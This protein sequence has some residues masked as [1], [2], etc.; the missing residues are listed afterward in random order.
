VK[1]GVSLQ[2]KRGRDSA[3]GIATRY[4]L[5]GP[6]SSPGGGETF[7]AHPYRHWSLNSLVYNGYR[8]FPGSKAAGAWR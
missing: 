5:D 4:G 1:I 2:V 7:R 6:G 8:V 3:V